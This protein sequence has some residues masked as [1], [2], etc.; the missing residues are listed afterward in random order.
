MNISNMDE[1]IN[2]LIS[3]FTISE[4]LIN[5]SHIGGNG[6]PIY[7]YE[8]FFITFCT[9]HNNILM[10]MLPKWFIHWCRN[11]QL[12]FTK[13]NGKPTIIL[14]KDNDKN[15]E[16]IIFKFAGMECSPFKK[17]ENN[18]YYNCIP[19]MSNEVITKEIV[20]KYGDYLEK[21]NNRKML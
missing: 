10:F 4:K 12:H 8:T 17:L 3:K 2:E 15:S 16:T 18:N 11:F 6:L 5:D 19:Y 20:E 14:K 21:R 13:R 1:L 9:W 7:I